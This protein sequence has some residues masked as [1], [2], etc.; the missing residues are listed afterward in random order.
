[1]IEDVDSNDRADA[2]GA[3]AIPPVLSLAQNHP[4]PFNPSTAFSFS[5]PRAGRVT[6]AR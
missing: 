5:L 3:A 4:N 6:L 2:G 1:L